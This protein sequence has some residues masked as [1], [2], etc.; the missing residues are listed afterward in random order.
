MADLYI[1]NSY[2]DR[3]NP[4]VGS[5]NA[6][7]SVHRTEVITHSLVGNNHPQARLPACG[8]IRT[9]QQRQEHVRL[10]IND[11]TQAIDELA[12]LNPQFKELAAVVLDP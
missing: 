1:S 4:R 3:A 2:V 6:T 12:M 8:E 10:K 7:F 11:L 9:F 5:D